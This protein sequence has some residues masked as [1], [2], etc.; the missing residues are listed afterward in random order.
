M[1]RTGSEDTLNTCCE[2]NHGH[3]GAN[4][5]NHHVIPIF[6]IL[7]RIPLMPSGGPEDEGKAVD[8]MDI[9]S[10][11]INLTFQWGK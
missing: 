3:A 6:I 9:A 2:I 10:A 7:L 4:I 5:N 11:L 8:D 1:K